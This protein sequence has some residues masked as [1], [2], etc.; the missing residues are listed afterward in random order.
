VDV[1]T[2]VQLRQYRSKQIMHFRL[3]MRELGM[4]QD[5]PS[6]VYEDNQ[7]AISIAQKEK[8]SRRSKHFMIKAAFLSDIQARIFSLFE[9]RDEGSAGRCF[10]QAATARR[11]HQIQGMDGSQSF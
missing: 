11:L 7:A 3:F 2:V 1:Q 4:G 5:G 6:V 9:G 10:H 8:Q